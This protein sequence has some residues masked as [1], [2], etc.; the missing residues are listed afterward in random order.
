M[1][2]LTSFGLVF[3][4]LL[5]FLWADGQISMTSVLLALGLQPIN[6][7]AYL[8]SRQSHL[9]AAS[10]VTTITLF[11][12]VVIANYQLGLTQTFLVGYALVVL[13]ASALAGTYAA[14]FFVL[15]SLG[16]HFFIGIL[17][18][19]NSMPSPFS[20]ELAML[21]DD[22]GWGLGLILL[23]LLDWYYRRDANKMLVRE[24]AMSAVLRMHQAELEQL[25]AARTAELTQTNEQLADKIIQHQRTEA[26]LRKSEESMRQLNAQLEQRV[27]ER[28]QELT[29]ANERLEELDRLKSKFIS[30]ISHELR[31]PVTNIRLYLE[32]L[33][34]GKSEKR[35]HYLKVLQEQGRRLMQLVES[36]L[37]FSQL[38]LDKSKLQFTSVSLDV[39]VRQIAAAW[40]ER[41]TATG[42]DLELAIY[43]IPPVRGIN[44]QLAQVV[45]ELVENA[46]HYTSNGSVRISTWFHKEQNRVCLEVKDTGQ[47][48]ASKD[49]PYLFD[50]FYRGHGDSSLSVPGTGL[51]LALVR[52]IIDL[53][54]GEITVKSQE[55][56]GSTF[57]VWLPVADT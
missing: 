31:T 3:A 42:L 13:T 23:T 4:L 54:G 19:A 10:R 7:L 46:V 9:N 26:A 44:T 38:E 52:E 41:V 45:E 15:L 48:I 33:K 36:V 34:Q 43:E 51:G 25:V 39:W 56:I 8:F 5:T 37:S 12:T 16:A 40:E 55:G 24:Q 57:R 2:G 18:L 30:D 11:I 20:P 32:L 6:L 22:A 49:L 47:G 28:T 27:S 50:R 21:I 14:L 17:R 53:H 1:L 35:N 29:R